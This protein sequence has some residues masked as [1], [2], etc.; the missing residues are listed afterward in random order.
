MTVCANNTTGS[1]SSTRSHFLSRSLCPIFSSIFYFLYFSVRTVQYCP[2]IQGYVARSVSRIYYIYIHVYVHIYIHIY[3]YTY[4]DYQSCCFTSTPNRFLQPIC[5]ACLR[6]GI[7]GS[8][9]RKR[10][11]WD[12]HLPRSRGALS[13]D[14]VTQLDFLWT[15]PSF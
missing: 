11:G 12:N 7:C 15:W 1:Q 3:I 13:G 9:S 10:A 6:Q 4:C 5:Q 14:R 2:C 8:G